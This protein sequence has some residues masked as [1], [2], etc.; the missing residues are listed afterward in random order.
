LKHLV[1]AHLS[2]QNNRPALVQ[3]LMAETLSCGT[4]D[5]VV[6]NPDH[7]TPWLHL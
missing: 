1:A 5:I 3:S 4:E 2:V 6:A 7:G